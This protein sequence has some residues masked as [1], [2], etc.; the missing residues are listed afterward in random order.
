MRKTNPSISLNK[1]RLPL[2]T[3]CD[4]YTLL[5]ETSKQ[6]PVSG[7]SIRTVIC[8]TS[9]RFR[10]HAGDIVLFCRPSMRFL[11]PSQLLPS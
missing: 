8:A 7:N 11:V 4:G 6:L 5:M 3:S 9:V 10:K 1:I 2:F